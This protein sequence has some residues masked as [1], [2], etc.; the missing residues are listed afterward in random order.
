MVWKLTDIKKNFPHLANSVHW[1][2]QLQGFPYSPWIVNEVREDIASYNLENQP[3]GYF[4]VPFPSSRPLFTITISFY[5]SHKYDVEKFINDWINNQAV[6][7][8]RVEFLDKVAKDLYITKYSPLS[9]GS[10][11]QVYKAHYKVVP[12]LTYTFEGKSEPV[13]VNNQITLTVI[14]E[15]NKTYS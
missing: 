11:K 2:V 4:Q 10:W 9:K 5:E 1:E 13:L 7:K 6:N 8:W 3:V 12:N 15:V 14:K